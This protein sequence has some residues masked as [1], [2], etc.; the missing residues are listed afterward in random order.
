VCRINKIISSPLFYL[1]N[2]FFYLLFLLF[3]YFKTGI[4]TNHEAEKYIDSANEILKGNYNFSFE[5]YLLFSSFNYFLATCILITGYKLAIVGQLFLSVFSAYCIMKIVLELT[6]SN[7]LSKISYSLFLFSYL[8]QFW[9]IT[10]FSESFFISISVI[11]LYT[12]ICK[13]KLFNI[14]LILL[15]LTIVLLFA[16]PQGVLFIMPAFIFYLQKNYNL[17]KQH[18]FLLF[19]GLSFVLF[20][21]VLFQ[22][23]SCEDVIRPISESSVICGFPEKPSSVFSLEKCNIFYAHKYLI[24]EYSIWYDLKMCSK[25]VIS[26]FILTR[27]YYSVLHNFYMIIHYPLYILIIFSIKRNKEIQLFFSII[28]LNLVLIALT[29]NEWHGRF[30]AIVF[31]IMLILGMIGLKKVLGLYKIN[32]N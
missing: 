3:L 16:R 2:L 18:S 14:K 25:K 19:C 32:I 23:N 10:L 22:K 21:F 9:V 24:K 7:V 6:N 13:K 1:I 30:T 5:N 27:D 31:P 29:F 20:G 15:L 8:I 17:K 12:I 4:I 11:L 28:F 26:F